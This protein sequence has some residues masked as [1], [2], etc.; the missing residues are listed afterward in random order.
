VLLSARCQTSPAKSFFTVAKVL[1]ESSLWAE[2]IVKP[3]TDMH[4]LLV[5]KFKMFSKLLW[6]WEVGKT[7]KEECAL[8]YVKA[9]R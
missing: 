4:D 6:L 3:I 9:H 7:N 2:V 1:S 5:K 8:E